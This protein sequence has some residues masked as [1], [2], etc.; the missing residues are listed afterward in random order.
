MHHHRKLFTSIHSHL[1]AIGT[2]PQQAKWTATFLRNLQESPKDFFT[3]IQHM[4][5]G[6]VLEDVYALQVQPSGQDDPFIAAATTAITAMGA[7]GIFGS[8]WVDYLPI[9]AWACCFL[10]YSDQLCHSEICA[11]LGSL[12]ELQKKGRGME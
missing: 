6:L 2:R 9:C 12:R 10:S 11:F 5:S 8:F 3:H 1:H 7:A 4:A